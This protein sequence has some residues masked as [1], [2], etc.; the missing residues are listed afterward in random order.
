MVKL[1]L[2]VFLC[3]LKEIIII[4]KLLNYSN[5]TKEFINGISQFSVKG[6]KE[7]KLK[8]KKAQ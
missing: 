8:C 1:I 5:F 2:E 7:A 4:N 6:N 3:L